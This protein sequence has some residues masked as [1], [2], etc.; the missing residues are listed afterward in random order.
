MNPAGYRQPISDVLD[1]RYPY[2][3]TPDPE[4]PEISFA[5]EER[6]VPKLTSIIELQNISDKTRILAMTHLKQIISSPQNQVR[7]AAMGLIRTFTVGLKKYWENPVVMALAGEI[8]AQ[9]AL[10]MAAREKFSFSMTVPVLVRCLSHKVSDVRAGSS[11]ALRSLSEFRDG[12]TVLLEHKTM[13]AHLVKALGDP[14][15]EVALNMVTMFGNVTNDSTGLAR[16]L[17]NSVVPPLIALLR[18]AAV[19]RSKKGAHHYQEHILRECLSVIRNLSH[20]SGGNAA[21]IKC[22]AVKEIGTSVAAAL[23]GRRWAEVERNAAAALMALAVSERGK[24]EICE[25]SVDLLAYLASR[26]T[27][28]KGFA[29]RGSTQS[30]AASAIRSASEYPPARKACLLSLLPNTQLLV[31]VFG[32]NIPTEARTRALRVLNSFLVDADVRVRCQAVL[33]IRSMIQLNPKIIV[34]AMACLYIVRNLALVLVDRAAND[35]GL[36]AASALDTICSY[37]T[38]AVGDLNRLVEDESFGTDG[39]DILKSFATLK[40]YLK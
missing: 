8:L 20:D 3:R 37:S 15:D 35:E 5:F 22:G 10:N 39:M 28:Q 26:T 4:E 6:T 18:R 16:S 12:V 34:E 9:L 30:N 2:E 29:T 11:A 40:R 14:D 1:T 13:M 17:A 19:L 36:V 32:T 27:L 33:A 25:Y 21:C 38:A 7:A 24:K 23:D 31:L